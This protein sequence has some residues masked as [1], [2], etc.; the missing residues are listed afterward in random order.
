MMGKYV[1]GNSNKV[2]IGTAVDR[3]HSWRG[4]TKSIQKTLSVRI[5]PFL[6]VD[7]N[8]LQAPSIS[9]N[10]PKFNQICYGL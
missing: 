4:S 9:Y 10:S 5:F 3:T 2:V 1:V 7:S 6:K 8:L